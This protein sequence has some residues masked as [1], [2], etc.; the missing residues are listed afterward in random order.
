MA[1]FLDG[2]VAV[3]TGSGRGIGR[4]HAM[5]LAAAGAAVVVCDIGAEVDGSGRDAS[6]AA[7]VVEEIT[8]AGGAAIADTSDISTFEGGA[9][10]VQAALEEFGRIDIL[11]NNAGVTGGASI[12]TVTM[13]GLD[14]V[15]A[16]NFIGTVATTRAAWPHLRSQGWGRVVNTVSEVALDPRMGGGG[17]GYGQAK[18]AV[19]SLTITLAREAELLGITVNALSPGAFTRMNEAMFAASGRPGLDLDPR[20]VAKAAAW[21]CSD[22]ASDVNGRIIHVAAGQHREYVTARRRDTELTRRIDAALREA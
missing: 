11:I 5:T 17:L 6:V 4:A 7:T 18:A 10:V 9:S 16:V 13:E 2:R 3:V 19:W 21:L 12:E 8:A 22:A 20:H 15:F 14:R 1:G